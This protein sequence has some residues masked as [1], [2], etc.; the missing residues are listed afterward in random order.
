MKIDLFIKI[1]L[2]PWL[3]IIPGAGRTSSGEGGG[4]I[5]GLYELNL[6]EHNAT[7]CLLFMEGNHRHH[8][9]LCGK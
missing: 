5:N 3:E 8:N 9:C 2:I 7:A 1:F 6:E 4:A